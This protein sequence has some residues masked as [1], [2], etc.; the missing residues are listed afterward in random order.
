M[1]PSEGFYARKQLRSESRLIAWS[2]R[3]RFQ[4][5]L[6]LARAIAGRRVLDYGFGDGTFLAMLC[7]GDGRPLHAVGAEISDELVQAGRQRFAGRPDLG[8]VHVNALDRPEHAGAY[9]AIICIEVLEH[10]LDPEPILERFARLLAPEGR[11]LVS[12]PVETGAPLAVKQV[13]RRVA[14][15]RGVG[16]YPGLAPYTIAEFGASLFAGRHQH[17]TRPVHRGADAQPFH[18][19]KGFNWLA[20]ERALGRRF[21]LERRVGSPVTWLPPHLNSQVWFVLA[22]A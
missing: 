13:A 9:D 22:P 5:A 16:D 2:H 7:D 17:I 20:L 12:V 4:I 8:F 6:D 15:W 18:C 3:G 10:V 14:G 19:H 1:S 21:R 11:L